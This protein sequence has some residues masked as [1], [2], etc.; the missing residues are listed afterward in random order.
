MFADV[1]GSTLPPTGGR[2][3]AQA[4]AE[5]ALLGDFEVRGPDGPVEVA[6]AN[7]RLILAM[8]ALRRGTVVAADALAHELWGPSPEVEVAGALQALVSRARRALR[9]TGAQLLARERGYLLEPATFQ[10][11]L[12]SFC[13]RAAAARQAATDGR[14]AEALDGYRAA[15]ALWRGPALAGFADREF[16]QADAVRLDEARLAALEAT[17]QALLQLS[18]AD[19]A[20]ALLEPH[21]AAHPFR[22]EA[23]ATLMVALHRCGRRA[24]AL[25]VYRSVRERMAD[26]LGLDPGPELR[27]A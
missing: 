16:A 20:A 9:P 19:E 1:G 24:D 7:V 22:E 21:V 14:H 2:T 4:V 10:V 6:G 25:A 13:S 17:A 23:A 5:F 3:V 18:R 11:D 26:E 8:L 15:L 12:E 27:R